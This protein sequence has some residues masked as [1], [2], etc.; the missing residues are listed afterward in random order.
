[1]CT[2]PAYQEEAGLEWRSEV[3]KERHYVKVHTRLSHGSSSQKPGSCA[4]FS[5]EKVNTGQI[6]REHCADHH[7]I[8]P[9]NATRCLLHPR[10][11]L[12]NTT[13]S[14]RPS[15]NAIPALV[16]LLN[17]DCFPFFGFRNTN[18]S[19]SCCGIR[20]K[21]VH[22]NQCHSSSLAY[23]FLTCVPYALRRVKIKYMEYD[24]ISK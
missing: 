19:S 5:R 7:H 3:G 1:M 10:R 11:T 17:Y 9:P 24:R 20:A 4:S 8:F 13:T 2:V 6:R 21:L 12:Y 16:H 14:P 22:G 23:A 15:T 18:S